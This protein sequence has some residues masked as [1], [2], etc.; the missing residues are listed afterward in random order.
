MVRRYVELKIEKSIENRN[1]LAPKGWAV[2]S[3][4]EGILDCLFHEQ[5][6]K[7]PARPAQSILFQAD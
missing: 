1:H 7:C 5:A 4:I 6:G 3:Y 2:I